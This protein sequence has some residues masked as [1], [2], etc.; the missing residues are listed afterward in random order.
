MREQWQDGDTHDLFMIQLLPE[1]LDKVTSVVS[2]NLR[3]DKLTILDGGDGSGIPSYVNNITGS[4][5][6]MLEQL[7]NATG[8]DIEK[9]AQGAGKGTNTDLPKELG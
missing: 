8:I 7:K 1:L 3:V 4:A 5:I 6:T 2:D 9:L